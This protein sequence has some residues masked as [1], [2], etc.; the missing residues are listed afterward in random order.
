M[1]VIK[2]FLVGEF[3][4]EDEF[5]AAFLKKIRKLK[6]D[7]RYFEI[8]NEKEAGM[9]DVLVMKKQISGF[10]EFKIS[11]NKGVITFEKTQPLFY[12]KNSSLRI[13]ILVWDVPRSRLVRISAE[14]IVENKSLKF[15]IPEVIR[16][17][18]TIS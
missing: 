15:K 14:T 4:S 2:D 12:K 7:E 16:D 3:L 9:P 1:I 18:A 17:S 13:L 10:L 5:K 6:P 8:E 11:D